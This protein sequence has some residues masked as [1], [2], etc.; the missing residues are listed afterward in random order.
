MTLRYKHPGLDTV[1]DMVA[2]E[3]A[4]Q[5]IK[6][7][8]LVAAAI[9]AKCAEPLVQALLSEH[10][11][12]HGAPLLDLLKAPPEPPAGAELEARNKAALDVVRVPIYRT[13]ADAIALAKR[14]NAHLK[15]HEPAL[16]A[17]LAKGGGSAV[18][19]TRQLMSEQLEREAI[20]AARSGLQG[21]ANPPAKADRAAAVPAPLNPVELQPARLRVR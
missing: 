8:K 20:G 15:A 17:R 7:P 9:E 14:T 3:C 5:G 11:N 18:G 12:L 13:K 10:P 16:H 6:N 21:S 4:S 2:A 19:V 1:R